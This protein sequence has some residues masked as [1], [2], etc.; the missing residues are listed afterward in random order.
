MSKAAQSFLTPDTVGLLG[1]L[2][3]KVDYYL[4]MGHAPILLLISPFSVILIMA[5]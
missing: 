2:L 5:R 1:H 4:G 3:S